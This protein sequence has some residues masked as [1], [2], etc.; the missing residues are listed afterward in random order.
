MASLSSSGTTSCISGAMI[1]SDAVKEVSGERAGRSSTL[2]SAQVCVSTSPHQWR[3]RRMKL[4]KQQSFHD[5][6]ASSR[7]LLFNNRFRKVVAAVG[8]V[9]FSIVAQPHVFCL[10]VWVWSV[11]FIVE[12]GVKGTRVGWWHVVGIA[13]RSAVVALL[14]ATNGFSVVGVPELRGRGST[15]WLEDRRLRVIVPCFRRRDSAEVRLLAVFIVIAGTVLV[16]L[17][18]PWSFVTAG[19]GRH[20]S[21]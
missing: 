3:M 4:T 12:I 1:S 18:S 5:R 19:A 21:V 6:G 20:R 8:W 2:Y 13:V 9:V 15:I 11:S 7:Q 17:G 14:V 10:F 16:V